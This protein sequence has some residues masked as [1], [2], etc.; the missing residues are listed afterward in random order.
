MGTKSTPT[1][2]V[3]QMD[4][5][6]ERAV[7]ERLLRDRPDD[8]VLAEE[9][10]ARTGSSRVRWIVD[11]LD[12][13]VNYVYGIPHY[14]VS[15]AAE[16]DGV[17]VAGAVYDPEREETFQAVAD[18]TASC[19]GQPLAVSGAQV[20]GQALVSTG[21]SYDAAR[22]FAQGRVAGRLVPQ[23]R[24]IRRFGAAALDLCWV[25]AGRVD[26]F[27]ELGLAPWDRAAG[28]LVAVTAGARVAQVADP[29]SGAELTVAATP[30]VFDALLAAL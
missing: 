1:D 12:G 6:A 3:T 24:D 4:T 20:L 27:F 11:P 22:R 7:I 8:S 29:E 28:E 19:G 14:A 25:A 18:G 17:V 16:V 13:T 26:A 9:G 10:G 2:L 30:G 23:V 15:V 5:A 21:F